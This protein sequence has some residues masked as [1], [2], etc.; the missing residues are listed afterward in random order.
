MVGVPSCLPNDRLTESAALFELLHGEGRR[1]LR[2]E[3]ATTFVR[4]ATG[5]HGAEAQITATTLLIPHAPTT[6][7]GALI[8]VLDQGA[9]ATGGRAGRERED[10]GDDTHCRRLCG[11]QQSRLPRAI[12]ERTSLTV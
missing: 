6:G 3:A 12:R 4:A 8:F 10:D 2:G 7:V 5:R 9:G 11:V 1:F